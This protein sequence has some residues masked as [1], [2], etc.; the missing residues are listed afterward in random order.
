MA[1]KSK[2]PKENYLKIPNHILNLQGIKLSEKVLL[3]HFYSFGR[4][5]CWQGNDTLGKM[6]FVSER[7]ITTWVAN[8]KKATC[9]LW[10][11]PKGR[12]RT[13]WAKTH[14]EVRE[15]QKLLYMRE[16]ISKNAVITGHAAEIL[17]GRNLP[18]GI[19]ENCRPTRKND[20]N[21]VGRKLLHTNNTTIKDTTK[22]TTATPTPL[23][24]GGQASALLDQREDEALDKIEQL[25][26]SFGEISRRRGPELTAAEIQQRKQQ[27]LKALLANKKK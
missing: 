14:P 15:A 16:E 20:C 19:E 8:L 18:E 4:K 27:Q 13:I 9:I 5:G 11:H 25:K 2:K 26:H 1:Q 10:V 7:T 17:L 24:A 3:A 22:D 6:F 12:Y 21:Q 23:P